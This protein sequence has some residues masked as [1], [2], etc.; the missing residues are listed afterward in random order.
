MIRS[1]SELAERFC[2]PWLW[3]R[4]LV[5]LLLACEP[6]IG[7]ETDVIRLKNRR[8]VLG[9]TLAGG[10]IVE[11]RLS[12]SPLNP[13]NWTIHGLEPVEADK[14][15]L[16]GHF[17]CLD[18]WGAPSQ[19]EAQ[20][21]VPFHGE[22]PRINWQLTRAPKAD[23]EYPHLQMGCKMPLAGLSVVRRIA[24]S[25]RTSVAW[26]H[27]EVTN[28]RKLGRIYNM[29][30]HPSIAAPFLDETTLV[31]SN[32]TL[33]FSQEGEVPAGSG[34]ASSWPRMVIQEQAVDLRQFRSN[35]SDGAAHDVSSFVFDSKTEVGW[36]TAVNPKAEL[37][38]GYTW[39]TKDY[40]WLN[41]WRHRENGRV[42]SRGL[43]FGTTGLHQPFGILVGRGRIFNRPLFSFIDAG[44]S[45]SRD[46]MMFVAAVPRGYAGVARIVVDKKQ[47]QLVLFERAP[48]KRRIVLPFDLPVPPPT[49]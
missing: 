40:P 3:F 34:S 31:D 48:G 37:L 38:L 45:V 18:R 49:K 11:F 26:V 36:V 4:L 47:S 23:D 17:L 32:A 22:A 44:A 2:V 1:S 12:S 7:A 13:L 6:C 15:Y 29:V 24:L 21:G 46:Y 10:G 8:A 16:R 33:G 9:V 42:K 43:E 41:I 27:E 39:Q 30:Q 19:A 5:L 28:T 25:R 14:P 20:R 35:E